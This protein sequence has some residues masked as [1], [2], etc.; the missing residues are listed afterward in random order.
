MLSVDKTE[1]ILIALT[2]KAKT[3][4][5]EK[6]VLDYRCNWY[7]SLFGHLRNFEF[8]KH[9]KVSESF[10]FLQV[11]R[12]RIF[13][14]GVFVVQF[15]ANVSEI[16][17]KEN[18]DMSN[19]TVSGFR[20]GYKKS[21]FPESIFLDYWRNARSSLFG[22]NCSICG[23]TLLQ[24]SSYVNSNSSLAFFW[25]VK[26]QTWRTNLMNLKL[27]KPSLARTSLVDWSLDGRNIVNCPVETSQ[28][29]PV[30]SNTMK[31]IASSECQDTHAEKKLGDFHSQRISKSIN[32]LIEILTEEVK[33]VPIN[34]I[35][36]FFLN[37]SAEVQH[38]RRR[39]R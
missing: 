17:G 39:V 24:L 21:I 3:L 18:A 28:K 34:K 7:I 29:G 2:Q 22:E 8:L 27:K 20:G 10:F 6:H 38:W 16:I 5:K 31:C 25:N 19:R 26:I 14:S 30:L 12:R 35:K 15:N 9:M 13:L 36:Y 1:T 37:R 11:F 32:L 23:K 4:V 33:A